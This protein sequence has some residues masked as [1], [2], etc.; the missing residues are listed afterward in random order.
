LSAV[1][2]KNTKYT[3]TEKMEDV[4]IPPKQPF[5]LHPKTSYVITSEM[6]LVTVDGVE[7]IP[8]LAVQSIASSL[9]AAACIDGI[10]A[11]V[12]ITRSCDGRT[13]DVRL[14]FPRALVTY[15]RYGDVVPV[16][17]PQIGASCSSLA[18][19]LT[20]DFEVGS[21]LYARMLTE[22]NRHLEDKVQTVWFGPFV[23]C[24]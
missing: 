8:M 12:E 11:S 4:Y 23:Y 3:D 15:G 19:T 2:V 21:V 18:D 5:C 16:Y 1:L 17:M 9:R 20:K 7:G 22:V 6:Q 10:R 14:H 13:Y 24:S